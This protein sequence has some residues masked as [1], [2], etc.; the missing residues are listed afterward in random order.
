MNKLIIRIAE[1]N[2][3]QAMIDLAIDNFHNSEYLLTIPEEFK[4]TVEQEEKWIRSF[5]DNP[6]SLLLVAEIKGEIIGVLNFNNYPKQRF[7]HAGEMGMS[8]HHKYRGK[9]IGSRLLNELIDWA[10]KNEK[11]EKICLRVF[12]RNLPAIGLYKKFG[13]VQEG[14]E[15][16]AAKLG[17]GEYWDNLIMSLF[18][19]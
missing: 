18:T 2:D 7:S 10:E 15:K 6:D 3:A 14:L 1:I 16:K 11:I 13:F 5:N 12:T 17:N 8:V 9:G 4:V 19:K